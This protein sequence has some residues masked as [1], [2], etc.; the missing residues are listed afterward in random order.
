MQLI[1]VNF[2]FLFYVDDSNNFLF[3]VRAEE[4]FFNEFWGEED[5]DDDDCISSDEEGLCTSASASA[6]VGVIRKDTASSSTSVAGVL[7][8]DIATS[9]PKNVHV[10]AK[11]AALTSSP[12]ISCTSASASSVS[13]SAVV[14]S[15]KI[16]ANSAQDG[17]LRKRRKLS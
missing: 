2:H 17:S 6:V 8:P 9:T 11:A 10:S 12:S 13:P 4:A 14:Q 3:C 16:G 5:L 7:K 15:S 1:F